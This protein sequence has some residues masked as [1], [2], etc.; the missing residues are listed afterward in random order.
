MFSVGPIDC[1]VPTIAGGVTGEYNTTTVNSVI[2]YQCEQ[3]GFTLSVPSS[4]CGEDERW[5]PDPSEVMC[6]M[7]TSLPTGTPTETIPNGSTLPT[8]MVK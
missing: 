4:V 1:R 8:G 2:V 3:P 5:N 6:R 7:M